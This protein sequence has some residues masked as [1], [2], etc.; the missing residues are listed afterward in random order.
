M[1]TKNAMIKTPFENFAS[2][3]N[4]QLHF[5]EV[6]EVLSWSFESFNFPR[7]VKTQNEDKKEGVWKWG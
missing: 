5:Y 2:N 3:F 6:Y 4:F 1:L 7:K